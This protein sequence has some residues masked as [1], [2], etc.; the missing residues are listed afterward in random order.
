MMQL[1]PTEAEASYPEAWAQILQ[2]IAEVSRCTQGGELVP[3][4]AFV[5]DDDTDGPTLCVTTR[6]DLVAPQTGEDVPRLNFKAPLPVN[7]RSRMR[8]H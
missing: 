3:V 4:T 8:L 2:Q 5:Y 7:A 1:A 6:T